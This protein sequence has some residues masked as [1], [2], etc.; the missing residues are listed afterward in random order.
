MFRKS[1]MITS[2]FLLTSMLSLPPAASANVDTYEGGDAL[3]AMCGSP[4]KDAKDM[5][6]ALLSMQCNMYLE[7]VIDT[8][9]QMYHDDSR[10]APFCLPPQFGQARSAIYNWLHNHSER[11][12]EAAPGLVFAALTEAFPCR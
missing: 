6:S 10:K 1:N 7:G 3:L 12:N 9:N 8:I 2:E 11:R 4:Q 5:D